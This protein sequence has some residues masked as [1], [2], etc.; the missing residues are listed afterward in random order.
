MQ[1]ELWRRLLLLKMT[2]ELATCS[3]RSALAL[4]VGILWP[5]HV[6]LTETGKPT[7]FRK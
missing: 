3:L 7:V 6:P 5:A 2:R 4:A 1:F